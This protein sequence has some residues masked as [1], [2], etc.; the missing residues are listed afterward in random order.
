[1]HLPQ[2]KPQTKSL[3]RAQQHRQKVEKKIHGCAPH[4]WPLLWINAID[5]ASRLRAAADLIYIK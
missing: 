4:S 1:V 5:D 3:S 2:Q